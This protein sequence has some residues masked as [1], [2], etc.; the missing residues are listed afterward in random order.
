MAEQDSALEPD[1]LEHRGQADPRLAAHVVERAGQ[2]DALGAAIAGARI[3][4]DA[5][6]RRG[7][8]FLRKVPPERDAAEPLVQHDDGRRLIGRGAIGDG[9]QALAV[10]DDLAANARVS[11]ERQASREDYAAASSF[12]ALTAFSLRMRS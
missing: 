1:R 12:S 8:E 6:T 5:V 4:E 7:R 10:G 11:T 2:G 3:G 9:L